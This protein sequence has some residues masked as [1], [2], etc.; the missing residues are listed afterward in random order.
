MAQAEGE[1]EVEEYKNLW[2][3]RILW[4][5]DVPDDIMVDAI[6]TSQEALEEVRNRDETIQ[7]V[8]EGKLQNDVN[9][10]EVAK[11]IKTKFDSIH[12]PTGYWHVIVGKNFGSHCV[13]ESR[14]FIY[15][16]IGTMA[17]LIYKCS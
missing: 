6:N 10:I 7:A 8:A 14:R 16:Y 15:F 11:I 12:A 17:F 2:G 1:K 4:P 3:A 9:L 13:H 5:C